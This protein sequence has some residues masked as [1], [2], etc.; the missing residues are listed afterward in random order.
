[1][2][3]TRLRP[4]VVN[5]IKVGRFTCIGEG[6]L[7]N[8]I[9]R[10]QPDQVHALV[11]QGKV[12]GLK[13][14]GDCEKLTK[15]WLE[16]QC[17]HYGIKLPAQPTIDVMCKFIRLRILE[18]GGLKQPLSLAK[19]EFKSNATFIRLNAEEREKERQMLE[20]RYGTTTATPLTPKPKVVAGL[21]IERVGLGTAPTV[22]RT[23]TSLKRKAEDIADARDK[24]GDKYQRGSALEKEMIRP[25]KQPRTTAPMQNRPTNHPSPYSGISARPSLS[26]TMIQRITGAYNGDCR[27]E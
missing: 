11:V 12:K 24:D 14:K 13:P 20:S 6:L 5:P 9:K 25:T 3:D 7:F 15:K 4:V 8:G 10:E 23:T 17:A 19:L 18:Y 26:R 2:S 22:A 27:L 21:R 16:A 1:M